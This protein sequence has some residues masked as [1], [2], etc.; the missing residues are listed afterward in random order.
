MVLGLAFRREQVWPVLLLWVVPAA[1]TLSAADATLHLLSGRWERLAMDGGSGDWLRFAVA[2]GL[3]LPP[4]E[5]LYQ[6]LVTRMAGRGLS[7]H[8]AHSEDDP[9][10]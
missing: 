3:L 4:I 9:P 7:Y 6:S 10:T 1:L 2:L 8:P 5:L